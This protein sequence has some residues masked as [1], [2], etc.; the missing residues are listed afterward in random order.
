MNCC[1]ALNWKRHNSLHAESVRRATSNQRKRDHGAIPIQGPH[2]SRLQYQTPSAAVAANLIRCPACL[3]PRHSQKTEMSP[4]RAG[5]PI[6]SVQFF[7]PK[8]LE[9]PAQ[10]REALRAHPGLRKTRE[11]SRFGKAEPEF[12]HASASVPGC[13]RKASRPWALECNAFGVKNSN[14]LLYSRITR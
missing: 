1:P 4:V 13:A 12:I 10:G 7:T 14:R 5:P 6:G 8:G 3:R 11:V 2:P 9:N